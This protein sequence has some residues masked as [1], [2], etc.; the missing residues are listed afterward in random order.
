LAPFIGKG[1][2]SGAYATLFRETKELKS[3]DVVCFDMAGLGGAT[4]LKKVLIP[5]IL[6]TIATNILGGDFSRRKMVIMDEAWRDLQ[7]G[8]M[9]DFM[10]DMYRTIRKLNG[11]VYILTQSFKDVVNSRIGGALIVNT[12]Y[13]YFVGPKHDFEE[14]VE[15]CRVDSSKCGSRKMNEFYAD[16]IAKSKAKQDFFLFC[17][18]FAGL[19]HFVPTKEFVMLASTHPKHKIILQKHR[20]KLGMDFVTPEVMESAK[21]EFV[22]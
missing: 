22:I 4:D 21:E 5:V 13:Y 10:M 1:H 14:M 7:G 2:N 8:S 9:S 18:F 16:V 15:L 12:S 3:K 19:L 6:E 20:K 17:P 11:G